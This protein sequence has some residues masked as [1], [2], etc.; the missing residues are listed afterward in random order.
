MSFYILIDHFLLLIIKTISDILITVYSEIS[1]SLT[2]SY[3]FI[4]SYSFIIYF[5]SILKIYLL[6]FIST[7]SHF[8]SIT[9]YIDD[10]SII[11]SSSSIT[12]IITSLI[13]IHNLFMNTYLITYLTNHYIIISISI[14]LTHSPYSHLSIHPLI[15]LFYSAILYS[16]IAM[17]H[18]ISYSNNLTTT[19]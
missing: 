6:I 5:I 15:S 8:V 11:Y 19:L 2:Q 13:Y 18:I 7:L 17:A 4:K 3:L 9:I 16:I 10:Y 14:M 12:I 1:A